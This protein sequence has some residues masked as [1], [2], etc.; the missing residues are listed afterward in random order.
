M[1]IWILN[2]YASSP[3]RAAAQGIM[4]LAA[5]LPSKGTR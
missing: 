1:K 2:H 4:N 3:D 5:Y